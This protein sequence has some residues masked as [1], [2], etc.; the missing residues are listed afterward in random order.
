[1]AFVLNLYLIIGLCQQHNPL[2]TSINLSYFGKTTVMRRPVI[3]SPKRIDIDLS[4]DQMASLKR[5]LGKKPVT[6]D[7]KESYLNTVF[8][9]VVTDDRT[10]AEVYRFIVNYRY[11]TDEDN[12]T[13]GRDGIIIIKVGIKEFD[14]TGKQ[15][16][17][18]TERLQEDLERNRCDKRVVEHFSRL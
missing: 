2:P 11:Y 17:A 6:S 3:L 4:T 13:I 1:M 9:R 14:I 10:F 18:F 15:L 16:S 5:I 8:D 7:I 12:K